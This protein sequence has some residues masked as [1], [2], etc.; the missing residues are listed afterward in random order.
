[1]SIYVFAHHFSSINAPCQ[2]TNEQTKKRKGASHLII[3]TIQER[4]TLLMPYDCN[5]G[6]LSAPLLGR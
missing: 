6:T 3:K 1:M 4:V 5:D 2:T